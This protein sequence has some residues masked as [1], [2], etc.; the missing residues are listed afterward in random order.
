MDDLETDNLKIFI[1]DVGSY[2][3]VFLPD[4]EYKDVVVLTKSI[5]CQVNGRGINVTIEPN[6]QAIFRQSKLMWPFKGYYWK[7]VENRGYK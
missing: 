5:G 1:I 4:V 7:M 2:S 3:T 6:S